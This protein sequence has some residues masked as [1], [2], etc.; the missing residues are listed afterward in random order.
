MRPEKGAMAQRAIERSWRIFILR[1]RV[2]P[3]EVILGDGVK[4]GR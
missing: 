1:H 2:L 3:V 4:L